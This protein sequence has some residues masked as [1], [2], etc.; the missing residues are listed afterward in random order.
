MFLCLDL[1]EAMAFYLVRARLRIDRVAE[2]RARLER[3][4]FRAMQPFGPALTAALENARWDPETG[5]A[6]WEEEDYC[7]PPLAM[8]RAAVLDHYFEDLRVE[9]VRSGEGW[10]RIAELP[11]LW[12]Q[13][14]A[15]DPEV[16]LWEGE[17]PA[18]D[19][20]AGQCG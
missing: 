3:G 20:A 18:C 4:E 17:G 13:P 2:L 11:S 14:F 1:E 9:R 6:V 8:E 15:Q 12:D 16:I 5:E 19:L 10:R 7:S